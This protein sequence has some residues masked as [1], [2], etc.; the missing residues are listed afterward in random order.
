MSKLS[1]WSQE[2]L[3]TNKGGEEKMKTMNRKQKGFTLVE[4]LIVVIVLAV[5]AGIVIPQFSSSTE[6]AKLAV[7]RSDLAT[8]GKA[9]ELYTTISTMQSILVV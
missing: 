7:L 4:L 5:L 8:M 6:D 3:P 2:A 1:K 9:V